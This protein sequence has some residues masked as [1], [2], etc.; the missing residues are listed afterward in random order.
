MAA[1]ESRRTATTRLLLL[2]AIILGCTLLLAQLPAPSGNKKSSEVF[3]NVQVLKDVPSD[4][5][6]PSM[7]FISSA[8]GVR[9]EYCHVE[10]AFD[11]DDKKPKQTAR[12]MI[13]MMF[14]INQNT[15][16]GHQEVTCYSCHR[17]N[18]KPVSIPVISDSMPRPLNAEAAVLRANPPDLPTP[19]AIVRKYVAALGGSDAIAK[20]ETVV[21]H[22]SA[23][24]GGR[25]FQ[26]DIFIK[27]PNHIAVV[28]HFPGADGVTA[29]DGTSG[30]VSFPGS[31]V[32]HMSEGDVDAA[33]MDADLHFAL[34]MQALF[35]E[36]DAMKKVTIDEKETILVIGK[37]KRMPD[38]EMYFDSQ[39]G[40]LARMVRYE[41]SPLGLNPT[42]LDYSD[43]RDAGGVKVPFHWTSTAPTGR[44]SVQVASVEPNTP[45][46][47]GMFTK[48][49]A[50]SGGGQ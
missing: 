47:D 17:G 14:A 15:F 20:L 29:S 6:I 30:F 36:L 26:Q 34:D 49:P 13:Q 19:D 35:S 40:L 21:E 39:T 27:S 38:V 43:Y 18:P 32:R 22:A 48:P 25:D 44:F 24:L 28:T 45:I 7:K 41:A 16:D 33:R 50:A 12:K 10:N 1:C 37:R 23:N 46:N 11:K 42:Q 2:S 3:K 9:C 8:L 5:L 31:P 4:Q